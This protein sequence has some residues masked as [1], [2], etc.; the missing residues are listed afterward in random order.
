MSLSIK[1][2]D[3]SPNKDVKLQKLFSI[4]ALLMTPYTRRRPQPYLY[5]NLERFCHLST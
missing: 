3:I 2:T 1:I 4:Y 5:I